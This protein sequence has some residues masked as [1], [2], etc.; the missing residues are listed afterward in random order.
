MPGN[1]HSQGWGNWGT[2]AP[3]PVSHW[4]GAVAGYWQA[5]VI[6]RHLQ[7]TLCTHEGGFWKPVDSP[8]TKMW[9]ECLK[10]GFWEHRGE[11][12]AGP[13]TCT[14]FESRKHQTPSRAGEIYRQRML[15]N[16]LKLILKQQHQAFRS[17]LHYI[18]PCT[19]NILRLFLCTFHFF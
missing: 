2:Y 10:M 8:V 3:T 7:P 19:C 6:P 9:L 1:N 17:L 4:V 14:M 11:M 5:W 18:C 12:R 16:V 15:T 13:A